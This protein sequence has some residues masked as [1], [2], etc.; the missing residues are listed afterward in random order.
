MTTEC[1]LQLVILKE[2]MCMCTRMLHENIIFTRYM[3][4]ENQAICVSLA[5][6]PKI[7]HVKDFGLKFKKI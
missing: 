6:L 5:E 4:H 3:I 2:V 7:R 1:K